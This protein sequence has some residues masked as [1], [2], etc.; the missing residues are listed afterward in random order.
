MVL[1]QEAYRRT[2][3]VRE[4]FKES[5]YACL[6][7]VFHGAVEGYFMEKGLLGANDA[8]YAKEVPNVCGKQE[9]YQ[10]PQQF[11]ECNHGMGHAVMFLTE[12]D[13]I[14]ALALC[15]ALITLSEQ[16]LCY[17]GAFMANTR[18]TADTD[19]PSKYL[20][21]PEDPLYP[22]PLLDHRYQGQCY[23][24]GILESFQGSTER[25]TEACKLIPR[26]YQEACFRTLGRNKTMYSADPL[27]LKEHCEQIP[28]TNFQYECIKGV[29][30]NLVIRFGPLSP[31]PDQFCTSVNMEAQQGCLLEIQSARKIR[32]QR[33]NN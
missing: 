7:G 9:E 21:K 14:R 10:I 6:A 22:C 15:D 16:E 20:P 28:E 17:T 23:S 33:E 29:A 24:Y 2:K 19:H 4:V 11:V 30:Y 25:S 8:D 3:N 12:N 1:G 32:S 13:L 18:G 5:S 26:E 27:V 31:L